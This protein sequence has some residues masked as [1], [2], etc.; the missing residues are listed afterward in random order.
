M[1]KYKF[2]VIKAVLS[3]IIAYDLQKIVDKFKDEGYAGRQWIKFFQERIKELD[4][5]F[6]Y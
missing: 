1:S 6:L 4:I 2:P 3:S 5:Y